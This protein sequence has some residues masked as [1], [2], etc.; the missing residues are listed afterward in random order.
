STCAAAAPGRIVLRHVR[1]VRKD[2]PR[3][4]ARRGRGDDLAAKAVLHEERQSPTMVEVRVG[5]QQEVERRRVE[6]EVG[7]VFLFEIATA[8]ENAT[9]HEQAP[10][11]T[12]QQVTRAGDR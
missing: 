11:G 1:R 3:E 12:L 8:L 6:A 10:P 2:D 7:G 9:I 4:V 5:Q